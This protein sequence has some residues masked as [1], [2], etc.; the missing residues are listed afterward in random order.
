MDRTRRQLLFDAGLG[1]GTVALWSLLGRDARASAS[2]PALHHPAR[3][4]NVIFLHLVGGPSQL[5]LFD[6][7]PT[8]KRLHGEPAP[9]SIL[10]GQRFAFIRGHP[11]LRGP[12][13]PFQRY[14]D[15][16]Q[17]FSDRLPHMAR[18]ADRFTRIRSMHTDEINHAPAQLVLHTGFGRFGRP[19]MGS[20]ISYGIGSENRDMPAYVAMI[21]GD[22]PGAGGSL[23]S[24]G[25]LPSEHH[26]TEFRS[27][28]DPVLFLSDPAGMDRARRR[29]V[30]DAVRDLNRE[31]A[32]A[33][34]D[35]EIESRISQYELAFRMQRAVPG[36]ADISS[37]PASVLEA[38]G[39]ES[40]K[41][42]FA[43]QC[44]LA[45]RLVE[46]GVRFVSIFD[47]GW[48]HHG[49]IQAALPKKCREVDQA[50][51]A[52]VEDLA[53]RGLL[54]ET[55]VVVAGE[56]GRTPMSQDAIGKRVTPPGRDHHPNAFTILAA[57]GG[58]KPG[59]VHGETD[60]LG[61][62]VASDPVHVHDLQATLLHLLGI[63]HARLT[64]SF[65]GRDFRL[66][67]V[68]GEVVRPVIQ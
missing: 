59:V 21:S 56:F 54:D 23:W 40:G 30:L 60:E 44:V 49:Y 17:E 50:I 1:L 3:A 35:P 18:I 2:A 53:Q 61:Y 58:M 19:S 16:G 4:K 41:G 36:F 27:Q 48:D 37:E 63:D 57:G 25:F 42:S 32:A 28:G 9:D 45:R 31:Q 22:V 67:D 26:G 29:R 34:G 52:L 38:Y 12:L 7:K 65:M 11:R 5:D 43:S 55:L 66:T 68:A 47:E 10:A 64:Y 6:F 24:S 62:H 51:A 20:W 15:S 14:G 8:L 46:G 13:Y 39:A 33:V